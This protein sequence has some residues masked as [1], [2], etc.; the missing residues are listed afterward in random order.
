MVEYSP[1]ILA[2][3]E[4]PPI[5]D[6]TGEELSYKE[7]RFS[8]FTALTLLTSAQDHQKAVRTR[9]VKSWITQNLSVRRKRQKHAVCYLECEPT[10]RCSQ[11]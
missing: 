1:K 10:E 3:E 7:T 2:S 6:L 11:F 9:S 4:K 8:V 5:R